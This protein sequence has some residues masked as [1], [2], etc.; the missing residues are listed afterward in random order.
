MTPLEFFSS[1]ITLSSEFY[2]IH[3]LFLFSLFKLNLYSSYLLF[4]F[5]LKILLNKFMKKLSL[6]YL[7]LHISSRPSDST[8]HNIL[9]NNLSHSIELKG[10]FPSGHSMAISAFTSLSFI[11]AYHL[12]LLSFH[13][14]FLYYSSLL[15][16]LTCWSRY[17]KKAHTILQ[18]TV[19]LL[20]GL[21]YSYLIF[22]FQSYF[23]S[24]PFWFSLFTH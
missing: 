3:S 5:L 18:I 21:P 6:R 11:N 16:I 14:I 9:D 15:L 22:I 19:G 4:M 1:Y 7:P 2:L 13:N 23:D 8:V 10:G 20:L 24:S 17:Q 12:N